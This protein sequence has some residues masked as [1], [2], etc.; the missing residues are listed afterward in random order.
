MVADGR[1]PRPEAASQILADR[2]L[3]DAAVLAGLDPAALPD[4]ASAERLEEQGLAA[5]AAVDEEPGRAA[6]G[7]RRPLGPQDERQ[8]EAGPRRAGDQEVQAS[9]QTAP[10]SSFVS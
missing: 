2:D 8:L 4:L 9:R 1:Q 3:D 5:P 6:D 10:N 7:D